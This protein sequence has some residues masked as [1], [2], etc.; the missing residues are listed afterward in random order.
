MRAAAVC[1]A[2]PVAAVAN[3]PTPFA[4]P[5]LAPWLRSGNQVASYGGAMHVQYSASVVFCSNAWRQNFVRTQ[6]F[7]IRA[8]NHNT[9]TKITNRKNK[10]RDA[11]Q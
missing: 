8:P 10:Y 3:T 5:T 1:R 2:R 7:T 11:N 4:L 6:L 9:N